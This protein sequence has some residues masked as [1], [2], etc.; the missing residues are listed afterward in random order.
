MSNISRHR[1]AE[2][3]HKVM[4]LAFPEVVA[5]DLATASQI[6]G[7]RGEDEYEALVVGTTSTEVLTS[8]GFTIGGVSRPEEIL[9]A[10]T[11]VVPGFNRSLNPADRPTRNALSLLR[12]AHAHGARVVSICTGAFALAAA[13]LLDGRTATTHWKE[14]DELQRRYSDVHVDPGVLYI[15]HGDVAT[16][17]GVAAGIDL[18][19]H[20]VR[21]DMGE[22]VATRI[23][24]RMVVAPQRIGGQAQFI[25]RPSP[26]PR[27][28][29]ASVAQWMTAHLGEPLSTSDCAARAGMS[30]RHFQRRFTAEVGVP[31]AEWLTRQRVAEVRRLLEVSDLTIGAIAHRTG[32]GTA[33]S[34]RRHILRELGVT[35]T[36]YRQSFGQTHHPPDYCR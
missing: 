14:A 5:F 13:G 28:G 19:L 6:F 35:P 24:R 22:Q 18:C 10:D 31:P 2:A 12:Q 23:A 8:T 34:L 30:V 33:T 7:F 11:V 4:I 25:D 32:M 27:G 9:H 15:D 29:I 17:A 1:G 3:P 26:E 16:S 21:R 36:A 20:L